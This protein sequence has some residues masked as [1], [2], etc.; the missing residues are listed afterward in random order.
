MSAIHESAV[1][2]QAPAFPPQPVQM[3]DPR[4]KSPALAAVLSM[5]PGLGQVYVG[6][7]QRGF[8]HAVVV[9]GMITLLAGEMVGQL[10]PM[11]GV[12]MSFFWLYNI[13]DAAR[14]ASLYNQYL[15]GNPALDPPEDFRMPR[16]G[17]SVFG[18]TCLIAVGFILLLHTRFGMPLDWMEE[19]WPV[20]PMIFGA[21]LLS[22][23]IRE[24]RSTPAAVRP[25]SRDAD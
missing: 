22:Q 23:A 17:G 8:I 19:W 11:F 7:Y 18:G 13:I 4:A 14:S 6:Y 2:H 21:Y 1:P 20:A 10:T 25:G 5:M 24:R 3:R 12:F 15:A 9:A 16:S